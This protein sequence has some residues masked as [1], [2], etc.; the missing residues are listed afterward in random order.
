[1]AKPGQKKKL[2]KKSIGQRQRRDRERKK[3]AFEDNVLYFHVVYKRK[4]K[5]YWLAISKY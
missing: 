1:M 2:Y 5:A 4:G 3:K